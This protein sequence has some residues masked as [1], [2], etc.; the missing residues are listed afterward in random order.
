MN[1]ANF[2]PTSTRPTKRFSYGRFILFWRNGINEKDDVAG[3][4]RVLC[5]LIKDLF[6][7][8]KQHE[9]VLEGGFLQQNTVTLEGVAL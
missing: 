4:W 1:S 9:E 5:S 3:F 8:V 2:N 7:M 6:D